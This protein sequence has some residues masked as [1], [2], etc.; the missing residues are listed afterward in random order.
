MHPQEGKSRG[1]E[2]PFGQGVQRG[3][4]PLWWG[5]GAKPLLAEGETVP[6]IVAFPKRLDEWGKMCYAICAKVNTL[7]RVA[8][9]RAQ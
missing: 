5:A 3:R 8:E 4:R 2:D 7:S 1:V 6:W 9:G